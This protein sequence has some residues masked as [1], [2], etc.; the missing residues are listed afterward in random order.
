VIFTGGEPT[1]SPNLSRW[2]THARSVG[3]SSRVIS[4]GMMCSEYKYMERLAKA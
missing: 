1:L 2:I 4:N 3:M